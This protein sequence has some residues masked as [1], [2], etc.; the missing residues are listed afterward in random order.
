MGLR[1]LAQ[2]PAVGGVIVI[3]VLVIIA[4]LVMARRAAPTGVERGRWFYDLQT[5][6][7]IV[8]DNLERDI[9][10][11]DNGHQ[12]V[13]ARVYS[14]GECGDP[15]QRFVGYLERFAGDNSA[16]P[17]NP[18]PGPGGAASQPQHLVAE[19][20]DDPDNIVWTSDMT[21]EGRRIMAVEQR[22]DCPGKLKVCTP[23]S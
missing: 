5:G 15:S 4:G 17:A 8:D 13:Q 20:A 9:A 22:S 23:D 1:E 10:T 3:V 18:T 12:A 16:M 19:P 21:V 14:C 7:L 2:K 11:L 6:K